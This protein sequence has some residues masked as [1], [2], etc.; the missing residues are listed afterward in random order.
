[1][2]ERLEGE[3]SRLREAAADS[4]FYDKPYDDIRPVLDRLQEFEAQLD[5]AVE[6]W[7]ELEEMGNASKRVH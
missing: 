7:S 4:E 5:A 3:V 6:R 1:M 2:I